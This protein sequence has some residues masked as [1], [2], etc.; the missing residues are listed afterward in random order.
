MNKR[1]W[2]AEVRELCDSLEAA[3][4]WQTALRIR[5]AQGEALHRRPEGTAFDYRLTPEDVRPLCA[6]LDALRTGRHSRH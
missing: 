1:V 6:A 5:V 4:A 3:G 2:H